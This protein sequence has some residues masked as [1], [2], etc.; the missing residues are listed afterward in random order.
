MA[1]GGDRAKVFGE[2]EQADESS[3]APEDKGQQWRTH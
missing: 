1:E 2:S 3:S